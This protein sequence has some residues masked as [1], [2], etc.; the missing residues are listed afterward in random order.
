MA[1]QYGKETEIREQLQ[2]FIW[3]NSHLRAIIYILL[4]PIYLTCIYICSVWAHWLD[5]LCPILRMNWKQKTRNKQTN[6]KLQLK[7]SSI[8]SKL[9]LT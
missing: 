6:E 7:V 1:K 4:K 8:K 5:S 3:K 2:N 9:G